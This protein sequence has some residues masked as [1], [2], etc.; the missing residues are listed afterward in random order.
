M[1]SVTF[2]RA[3][4]LG[5]AVA[6]AISV[7]PTAGAVAAKAPV[8]L[9]LAA[10][11]TDGAAFDFDEY[12]DGDVAVQVTNSAK[13]GVDVD[14][15]RDL[16][17]FW[18]IKPFAA[19]AAVVR[20]PATGTAVQTDD[21]LG[22][23]AVPVP[24]GQASGTY[25]LTAAISAG[26][27][28]SALVT[29]VTRALKVG[30]AVSTF[31]D[32]S[33]LR[34]EPGTTR[35]L[36]G[37]LKL[38]DGTGLAGRLIDLGITRGTVGSDL[39]ADAGFVP[40]AGDPV[41]DTLQV[42]TLPTGEFSALLADPTED[43]QGSELGDVIHAATATTPDIGN[44]GAT[45]VSLAVDYVWN[46]TSPRGTSATIYPLGG[47]T[48]GESFSSALEITAPDDTF[49][50]D[51][52]PGMQGDQDTD[53]DPVAG[54]V[55]AITLDHG[56]FT[57]GHGP[58]P[59]VVGTPAGDLEQ[60]GTTLTGITGPDGQIPFKVG[61]ARDAGFDDDGNVTATVTALVGGVTQTRSAV[62]D[63]T[64]PLN[65]RV[66]VALSAE[67]EQDNPVDPTVS[68][69]SVNYDVLALDQFGNRAGRHLIELAYTGDI[70]NWDYSDD[71]KLSDFT[72]ASDI[73]LT[74]FDP[75]TITATGTWEDAPT[76]LYIDAAGS[77]QAGTDIAG[78]ATSASFYN[79]DFDASTFTL[80]SSA[81]DVVRV[82]TAVTQTVR[83]VDQLG[84]PVR[85][86]EVDFFRY[87][88]DKVSG[89][90]LDTGTTNARGEASYTFIGT[91]LGRAL[92]TATVTDGLGS[93]ELNV[94]VRFGSAVTARL[95]AGKGGKGA[96]RLTVTA[97]SVAPGTRVELYRV[98]SGIHTRVA[99]GKLGGSGKA[100][101]TI[102]DRNANAYTSYVALVRSTPKTVADYSGTARI[103]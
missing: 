66:S 99:V 60:L 2:G 6:L 57:T 45:P 79:V 26:K 40:I 69:D 36:K 92:V 101:F 103:R 59:S 47:G 23:F 70:D 51:P 67:S 88:P 29:G 97:A 98:V 94:A 43:G 37:S 4:G 35:T 11:S 22:K 42:A 78:D 102:K 8:R 84:N 53:R 71:S 55:Y 90:A 72:A 18:T 50:A 28:G 20:V 93:Q 77:S 56:F 52:A 21:V 31:A 15:A 41:Q 30:N 24:Q 63:S 12:V 58:L 14:D 89:E 91:K 3:L 10:S 76:E 96:D 19:S 85:G 54:Q 44:A 75:A 48:P 83:V 46:T 80:T 81:T 64:N 100:Q 49:D 74:S 68:G 61:M 39:D 86:Y 95:V 65:G 62:W 16:K 5:V 32:A 9:F 25:T 7:V 38:E 34:A 1:H 13:A 73:W 17:Y 87:G 82:G 27:S 33:P